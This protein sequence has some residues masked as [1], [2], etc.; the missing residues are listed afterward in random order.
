MTR[1]F[2]SIV[3]VRFFV[4]LHQLHSHDWSNRKGTPCSGF[5]NNYGNNNFRLQK[6]SQKTDFRNYEPADVV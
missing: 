3:F 2:K 1:K 5:N 6:R 4:A